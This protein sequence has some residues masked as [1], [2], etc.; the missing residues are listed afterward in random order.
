MRLVNVHQP[1]PGQVRQLHQQAANR[2]G[3]LK[4]HIHTFL[5][6]PG[7]QVLTSE[8]GG[9]KHKVRHAAIPVTGYKPEV[10][11]WDKV[12]VTCD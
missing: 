12:P 6:H 8:Q 10:A 5:A 9:R 4:G 3:P 11:V 1:Q 7:R 2:Q